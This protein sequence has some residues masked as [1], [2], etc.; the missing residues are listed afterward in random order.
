MVFNFLLSFCRFGA[1]TT[2]QNAIRTTLSE[3]RSVMPS[4]CPYGETTERQ[5]GIRRTS[6]ILFHISIFIYSNRTQIVIDWLIDWLIEQYFVLYSLRDQI[7]NILCRSKSERKIRLSHKTGGYDR[8][9]HRQHL[10][11]YFS[12]KAVALFF[13]TFSH[14]YVTFLINVRLILTYGNCVFD[15]SHTT[16]EQ[17]FSRVC[18]QCCL[19]TCMLCTACFFNAWTLILL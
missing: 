8:E 16:T 3:S 2:R 6:T 4:S 7:Y 14:S 17:T 5:N 15:S 9:K 18:T 13:L 12:L 10:T 19:K 1:T 11:N